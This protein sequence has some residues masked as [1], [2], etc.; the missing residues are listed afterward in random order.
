MKIREVIQ[1]KVEERS[2]YLPVLNVAKTVF[3]EQGFDN[4]MSKGYI[5]NWPEDCAA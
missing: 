5:R 4:R 3:E 2:R 1:V